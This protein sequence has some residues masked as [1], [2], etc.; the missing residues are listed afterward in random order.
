MQGES[1]EEDGEHEDLYDGLVWWIV[2]GRRDGRLTH[3]FE[4]LQQSS[5]ETLLPNP[6]PHYRQRDVAEPIEDYDN[7]KPNFPAVD[8]IFVQVAVE[9]ADGEVVRQRHDPG[10]ADGVVRPDVGDDGDFAGEAD[11]AEEEAAEE[12]GEGAAVGP[13]AEGVEE[14]LVAAVGVSS[15][16]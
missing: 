9:P 3:P 15:V 5:K 7:T 16:C 14:E 13:G 4:V 1:A 10:C 8:V 12:F 2:C 11:V 6:V